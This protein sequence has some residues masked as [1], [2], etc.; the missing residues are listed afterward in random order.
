[1]SRRLSRPRPAHRPLLLTPEV[2]ERLVE[3]T[4]LGVSVGLA[5]QGAGVNRATVFRWLARGRAEAAARA[6][7]AAPCPEEEPF[8]TLYGRIAQ[9]RATAAARAVRR[10]Q[11]AGAG[12][13]VVSSRTRRFR[14][15]VTGVPVEETTVRRAPPD[16]RAFAWL[17]ERL[18]PDEYGKRAVG[19]DPFDAP[20]DAGPAETGTDWAALSARLELALGAGAD[21]PGHDGRPSIEGGRTC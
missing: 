14:D 7:G 12:G 21:L 18:F 11:Q 20:D 3:L 1:M 2:E 9:A 13:F 8:A 10:I 4:G 15:P 17:L 16:W 6:A 19:R 5:A